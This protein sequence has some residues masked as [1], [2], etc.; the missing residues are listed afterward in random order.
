MPTFPQTDPQAGQSSVFDVSTLIVNGVLQ[1]EGITLVPPTAPVGL[2]ATFFASSGPAGSNMAATTSYT[3][4]VTEV[5]WTGI[6]SG[7]SSTVT[8]ARSLPKAR[9]AK[10]R[11]LSSPCPCTRRKKPRNDGSQNWKPHNDSPGR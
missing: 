9:P 7:A 2:A 6:E 3:Y 1:A 5:S 4:A 8:G 10:V 11:S